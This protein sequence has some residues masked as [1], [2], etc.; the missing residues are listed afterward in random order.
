MALNIHPPH[1]IRLKIRVALAQLTEPPQAGCVLSIFFGCA[2]SPEIPVQN[3]VVETNWPVSRSGHHGRR[4][5]PLNASVL[6][7]EVETRPF[8]HPRDELLIF[9]L[10]PHGEETLAAVSLLEDPICKRAQQLG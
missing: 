1:K 3:L 2:V 7:G 10:H 9:L 6:P 5:V 4:R 8:S